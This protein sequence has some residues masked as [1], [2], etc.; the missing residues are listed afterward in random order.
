MA[1]TVPAAGL[2][3]RVRA[4]SGAWRSS[5]WA[6]RGAEEE[7]EEEEEERVGQATSHLLLRDRILVSED[8]NIDVG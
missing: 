8:T 3:A 7:E 2:A 1:E 4:G 6:C 5:A